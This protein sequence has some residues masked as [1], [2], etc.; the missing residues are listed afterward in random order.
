MILKKTILSI[1]LCSF[2]ALSF[3]EDAPK[4]VVYFGSNAQVRYTGFAKEFGDAIMRKSHSQGHLYAG[5]KLSDDIAIEFGR[6]E[7]YSRDK[8]VILL[9]GQ[10]FNGVPIPKHFSPSEFITKMKLKAFNFDFV[11]Y[12]RIFD[13]LPLSLVS[14]AGFSYTTIDIYRDSLSCGE[15]IKKPQRRKLHKSFLS[16]RPSVGLQYDFEN[17]FSLRTSASFINTHGQKIFSKDIEAKKMINKPR[18]HLKDSFVFGVG[19]LIRL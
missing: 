2:S 9:E 1:C 18:V 3:C 13:D 19:F 10:V 8:N 5:F 7:V 17:G 16:L 12:Q 6:E 11:F 15:I 14:S 4:S